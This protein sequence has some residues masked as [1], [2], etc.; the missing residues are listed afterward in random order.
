[1]M[2]MGVWAGNLSLPAVLN[3]CLLRS[4]GGVIRIFPNTRGPGAAR[5]WSLR[6]VEAFRVSASG[7]GRA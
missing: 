1:M 5:F 6:A 7:T 2:R 3:E 4:V